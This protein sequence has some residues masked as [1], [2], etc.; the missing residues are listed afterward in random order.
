MTRDFIISRDDKNKFYQMV[1]DKH[2]MGLHGG[3]IG[4]FD[5][6]QYIIT[7]L[8][9][10]VPYLDEYKIEYKELVRYKDGYDMK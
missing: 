9:E 5:D 1:F 7:L 2:I 4:D 8:D 6:Y 10:W 3:I